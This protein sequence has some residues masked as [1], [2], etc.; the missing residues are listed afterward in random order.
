MINEKSITL[1]GG[2]VV[3]VQEVRVRQILKVLP[4]LDDITGSKKAGQ[5]EKKTES[6]Q[7]TVVVEKSFL[8]N[9]TDFLRATCGLSVQELEDLYPSDLEKLWQAF[10]EV[11]SFFF[12]MAEKLGLAEQ[13]GT[14]IRSILDGVGNQLADSLKEDIQVALTMAS[15]GLSVPPNTPSDSERIE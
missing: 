8:E 14:V 2:K 10:R 6:D 7:G 3:L 4:F 15:A 1:R 9:A 11:N 5:V 13:L 12:G